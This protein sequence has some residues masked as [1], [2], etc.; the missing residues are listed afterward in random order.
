MPSR[1]FP[2]S[3]SVTTISM[4]APMVI[5]WPTFLDNTSMSTLLVKCR[6]PRPAGRRE[7]VDVRRDTD[8]VSATDHPLR[9]GLDPVAVRRLGM[10]PPHPVP[11]GLGPPTG[12]H[13]SVQDGPALFDQKI[14]FDLG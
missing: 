5:F 14:P 9:F 13:Q 4:S 3:I 2:H 10:E 12:H 1:T 7:P 8:E 11:P 6:H